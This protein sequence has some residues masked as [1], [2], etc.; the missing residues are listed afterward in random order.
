MNI[1]SSKALFSC[2]EVGIDPLYHYFSLF[3]MEKSG[4]LIRRE[5]GYL[6]FTA[7]SQYDEV[8]SSMIPKA[9]GHLFYLTTFEKISI[10]VCSPE[11]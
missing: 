7:H 4:V 8:G 3:K 2:R 11:A 10:D 6:I 5:P 1:A 9:I